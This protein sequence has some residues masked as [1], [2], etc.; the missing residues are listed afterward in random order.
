[1]TRAISAVAQGDLLETV[2]FDIDGRPLQGEF[3]RSAAI[4]KIMIEQ[5]RVFRSW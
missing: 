2:E 1:M 4:V 5:L 3:L